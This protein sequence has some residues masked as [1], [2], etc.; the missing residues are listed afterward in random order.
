MGNIVVSTPNEAVVISGWGGSKL[1]VGECGFAFWGLQR[2]Q[3]LDIG[4]RTIEVI[5]HDAETKTSNTIDV[6]GVCQVSMDVTSHKTRE[7]NKSFE[8][9]ETKPAARGAGGQNST[10]F[11][12]APAFSANMCP[13]VQNFIGL[14]HAEINASIGHTL[15]GHHRLGS[16]FCLL[17]SDESCSSDPI[18]LYVSHLRS[19]IASMTIE[20]VIADKAKFNSLVLESVRNDL[21]DLGIRIWSYTISDISDKHG[22]IKTLASKQSA[23]VEAEANKMVTEYKAVAA[24]DTSRAQM[25]EEESTMRAKVFA[26][27]Q[28]SLI[29]K[30]KKDREVKEFQFAQEVAIAK[31]TSALR[32]PLEE[33]RLKKEIVKETELQKVEAV[34]VAIDVAKLEGVRDEEKARGVGWALIV[35]RQAEAEANALTKFKQE[36]GN[37][38]AKIVMEEANATTRVLMEEANAKAKVLMEEANAKSREIA[39]LVDSEATKRIGHAQAEVLFAQGEVE[40]KV[41]AAKGKAEADAMTEKA[42]AFNKYGE[43][44]V[45]NLIVEALPQI[46]REIAAP[47]QKVGNVTVFASGE[48]ASGASFVTKDMAQAIAQI[49]HIVKTTTGVDL[50]ETLKIAMASRVNPSLPSGP[51]E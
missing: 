38:K 8:D 12:G 14:G 16:F 18:G 17:C 5:S 41:I 45:V 33:A 37:A 28:R 47:M 44:A 11:S 20:D 42:A 13:A 4:I 31:A 22:Y 19:I 27:E 30:A 26:E 9:P 43:A 34:T 29:E 1:F 7:V 51:K 46:A 35:Q 25:A 21:S 15:Q 39:A 32:G 36:E 49:P 10:A 48:G 40:A 50:V 2:T 23:R 3:R 24:A 6:V